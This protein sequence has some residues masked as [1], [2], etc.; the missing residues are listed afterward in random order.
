ASH[1]RPNKLYRSMVSTRGARVVQTS[2]PE[3]SS[4]GAVSSGREN[5]PSADAVA[6]RM[7][8][9]LEAA[10][11]SDPESESAAS[12]AVESE[13]EEEGAPGPSRATS[14]RNLHWRPDVDL[15]SLE[16]NG[17]PPPASA[18][19][20][21]SLTKQSHVPSR[22]PRARLRAE[23]S[24]RPDTAGA[25]WFNL[26]AT[27]LTDE[28]KRDLKVL[29]LRSAFQGNRFY[30]KADSTKFP[31]HFQIGTVV[32]GKAEWYS[33]RIAR[34][35]RRGTLAEEILSDPYLAADRQRRYDKLQAERK[36]WHKRGSGDK[37]SRLP[38][39]RTKRAKH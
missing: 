5:E 13:E 3:I 24:T 14:M 15:S 16:T 35:D 21:A 17:R 27:P 32:E 6:E 30:K 37:P 39:P 34:K 2:L 20:A 36:Q 38:H 33:S 22:D 12:D 10:S 18:T 8:A 25:A 11:D 31:K 26:P 4:E 29:Q 1:L 19:L 7:L 23:R 28:V 9:A